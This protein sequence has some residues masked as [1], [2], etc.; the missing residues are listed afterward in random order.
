MGGINQPIDLA[1]APSKED[2]HPRI[3]AP[4]HAAQRVHRH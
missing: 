1:A 4:R 3:E 2:L